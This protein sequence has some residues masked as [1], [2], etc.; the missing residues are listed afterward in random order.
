MNFSKKFEKGNYLINF[1]C[2]S[3]N[4]LFNL[5]FEKKNVILNNHTYINYNFENNEK[6]NLNLNNNS[7]FLSL[8]KTNIYKIK[9]KNR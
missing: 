5:E 7:K 9:Q 4:N 2:N 1:I 8:I 6:I 3:K